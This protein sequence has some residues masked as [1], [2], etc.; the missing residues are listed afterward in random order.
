MIRFQIR[1]QPV[2]T[3]FISHTG[4]PVPLSLRFDFANGQ[5]YYSVAPE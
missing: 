4:C 2:E 1:I 5:Q 3:D